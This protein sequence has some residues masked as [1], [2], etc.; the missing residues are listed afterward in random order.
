[1]LGG[2]SCYAKYLVK[3]AAPRLVYFARETRLQDHYNYSYCDV[4]RTCSSVLVCEG[5]YLECLVRRMVEHIYCMLLSAFSLSTNVQY[6]VRT[7]ELW[8]VYFASAAARLQ[9]ELNH[10]YGNI[11]MHMQLEVVC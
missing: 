8:L 11:Y 6:L 3:R 1:M 5:L 10:S 4:Y 7:A 2:V 9:N